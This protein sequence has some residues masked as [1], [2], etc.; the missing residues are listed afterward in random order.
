MAV[1]ACQSN[2]KGKIVGK[3]K[4]PEGQLPNGGSMSLDF[5]ADGRVTILFG[6]AYFSKRIT[7]KYSLGMSDFVTFSDLSEC[8]AGRRTHGET[9]YIKGN[10]L[11]MRDFDGTELTFSR[12]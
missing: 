11:R 8:V 1:P 10:T 5:A 6:N 3:W 12:Y 7:G 2:N 9:V 4:T